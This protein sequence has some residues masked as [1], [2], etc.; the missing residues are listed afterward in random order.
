AASEAGALGLGD[1]PGGL[2][3]GDLRSGLR[4][5]RRRAA[6]RHRNPVDDHL[7]RR[8]LGRADRHR[9]GPVDRRDRPGGAVLVLLRPPRNS[10]R[11][12]MTTNAARLAAAI[13]AEGV[14]RA[15]GLIGNG[16]LEVIAE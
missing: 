1:D 3:A 4:A 9:L 6:G 16:N 5:D 12:A 10:E 7:R 14:T 15:F 8:L 11:R 13:V 2:D